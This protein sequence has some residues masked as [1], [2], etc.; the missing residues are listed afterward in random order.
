MLKFDFLPKI[1]DRHLSTSPFLS[2]WMAGYE[3]SDKLNAFGNR[4]DLLN[5][6]G[7]IDAIWEDY[8]ALK[9]FNISTV[10]EGIRWSFIEKQPYQYDFSIVSEM[11]K[12]A[13]HYNIQQ[14][15]DLCHFGYP[16]D[17]SPLHPMFAK[18]F[19]A[20][21]LAFIE[22]YRSVNPSETLIIIPIN[23]VSFISWL[24]G[25]VCAT[26]PYCNGNGW[27]VKY[28]LMQAYI[29][30]VAIIKQ[31]D[32]NVIILSSEPLVNMV[33]PQNATEEE[34]ENAA[35][36]HQQQFQATDILCG[37]ICPELK[38]CPEYLDIIGVNYY[39]NNQWI[40]DTSNFLVWTN[41]PKDERWRPLHSLINEVYTRYNCPVV[42]TETSHP[43][44]DRPLWITDIA[45]E[46]VTIL[47]NNIPLFG[48][49][50]YPFIDRPDWNDTQTWHNAGI[51]DVIQE[52]GK[53][54]RVLYQPYADA[55]YE[56][57]QLVKKNQYKNCM[58]NTNQ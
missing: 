54:K 56:A 58:Q 11:I 35:I 34:I 36:Q 43:K 9:N 21:C 39:Y 26:T 25:E 7:H 41:E 52:D 47:N 27:H 33:P 13:K 6:T 57:Q 28:K 32:D 53:L 22:F 10:R 15:W 20:L 29:E 40:I 55:F 48:V 18:R 45:N 50:I 31:A 38:G 42:I 37:K 23:E 17:L 49:C 8:A 12:A 24:G 30:G 16:D 5:I 46:V 3:C 14:V 19:A 51:W 4:V 2:F 44:E 1:Y